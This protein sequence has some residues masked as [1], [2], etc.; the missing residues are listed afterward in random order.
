VKLTRKVYRKG[1]R[2]V[3]A[4]KRKREA[5]LQRHPDLPW[6]DLRINPRPV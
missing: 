3:G 5:R 4:A 1:Q 2:L 6:W